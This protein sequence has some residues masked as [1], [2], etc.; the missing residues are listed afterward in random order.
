M[1][2]IHV[3]LLTAFPLSLWSGQSE[4]AGAQ[5]YTV[6]PTYLMSAGRFDSNVPGSEYRAWGVMLGKEKE[7]QWWQPHL[8]FQRYDIRSYPVGASPG[9]GDP[10]LTGWSISVGPSIEFMDS[11]PWIGAFVPQIGIKSRGNGSFWGG[12]GVHVGARIGRIR[13]QLFGRIQHIAPQSFWTVG[14]GVSLEIGR[15]EGRGRPVF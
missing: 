10:K 15:R 6:T 12:A 13:P 9:V 11:D 2:A 4:N 7:G 3:A 1:R 5:V 14:V 8:W